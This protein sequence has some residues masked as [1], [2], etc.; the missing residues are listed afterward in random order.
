MPALTFKKEFIAPIRSGEKR[1]TLRRGTSMK[2]G[3]IVDF[4]CRWGDPPFARVKITEVTTLR[5][6]ELRAADAHADGFPTLKA[7]LD[8][9]DGTYGILF[10]FVRVRFEVLT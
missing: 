7:M 4:Y 8:F 2:P 1:Q 10:R 3:D 6:R 5:R 9:V